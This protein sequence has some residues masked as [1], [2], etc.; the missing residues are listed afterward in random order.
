MNG[1]ARVREPEDDHV[2]LDGID[3]QNPGIGPASKL[4]LP[5]RR[6]LHWRTLVVAENLV[7]KRCFRSLLL[8]LWAVALLSCGRSASDDV[9]L[10]KA[11]GEYRTVTGSTMGTYYRVL[12]RPSEGCEI[13]LADAD[14][15]L[16]EFNLSLST[17][18]PES[19]ISRFNGAAADQWID[20]T[21][22]MN[23][24][25][26]AAFEVWR[27]SQGAFD[28]TIGPLVNLWGF[29][30][31]EGVTLPTA[32]AQRAASRWVGMQH[33]RLDHAN[34]RAQKMAAEV[35]VDLSALAKGLGVDELA[36]SLVA[37]SCTDF[38]VDI[39]GEM[40]LAGSNPKGRPWQIGV[41][42]PI[43]GRL[44]SIQ[45]V[46]VASDV[47]V[48][49]SGDYRNFREVDGVRVDHVIDPRSGLPAD[50]Q[51]ASVTV[52]HPEA[53]F[54]DA[55]ATSIMVLGTERGLELAQRLALPALIIEKNADGR[56][57]EH[58]TEAMNAFLRTPAE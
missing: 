1:F 10:G 53:M 9:K 41:E 7:S 48:A 42:R 22:R 6:G 23:Q 4:R 14:R 31:S 12:Y 32:E 58:Y 57:R 2:A 26:Q 54:A 21:P 3:K 50:N 55:Y 17:Y 49:T 52:I 35:Y 5:P 18:I 29:G 8:M 25:L 40:R 45:R 39:G 47:A 33:L 37:R 56:F 24:V 51:V 11:A 44:G 13:S 30:P 19:E 16:E 36:A 46:L 38:M 15:L 34:A 27:E 20:L 28:V 43:P